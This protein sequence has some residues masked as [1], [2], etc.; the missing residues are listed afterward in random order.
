MIKITVHESVEEALHKAFP[1]PTAS[2]KKALAKYVAVVESMLFDALQHGRTPEQLKLNLYAVSLDQLA[3]KGGQIGPK[4]IRI[5]K[6]LREN[7]L[8][9]LE[10]VVPGSKFTGQ[11]SQVKLTPLI[12]MQNTLT[13]PSGSI[14]A[15]TTDEEIDAYLSGDPA[16]NKALFDHLYPE[17]GQEWKE[18]KL[19][20]L[21]HWVP[22]DIE[23]VKA[24]LYWVE[25]ES[26]HIKEA[27]KDTILRQALT[28]IGVATLTK[29][30]YVQRVKPSQFGRT[31]YEGTSVQNVN[32]DLRRAMLGNCWEYDI[33]SSV[34]AWK[35]GYARS[36]LC[37]SG[38]DV[39]LRKHFPEPAPV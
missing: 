24:Y 5:H 15:A 7:N 22:V 38:L 9:L 26:T 3:N 37:D 11:N 4:K 18:E 19:A 6:W 28:I 21:F 36:L 33:R 2:A 14:A 17:Y 12:T 31:Y 30:Y 35:M 27:Q 39:D 8:E 29:G 1:R 34:V 25:I 20:E 16:S 32:K 13:V 10:T 23:S